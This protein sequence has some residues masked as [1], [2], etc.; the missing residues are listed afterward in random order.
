MPDP[1]AQ[2]TPSCRHRSARPAAS[3]AVPASVVPTWL[4]ATPASRVSSS[5]TSLSLSSSMVPTSWATVGERSRASS[6]LPPGAVPERVDPAT[7][8]AGA[9]QHLAEQL[10]VAERRVGHEGGVVAMPVVLDHQRRQRPGVGRHLPVLPARRPAA[11]HVT[12]LVGHHVAGHPPDAGRQQLI[13][14]G[15]EGVGAVDGQ[16]GVASADQHQVALH[17]AVDHRPAGGHRGGEGLVGAVGRPGRR[18]R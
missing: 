4:T 2:P 5:A 9:G 12:A 1:S 8:I 3:A 7:A 11:A 14:Q 13:D 16:R 15:A 18:P 17:D 6:M 10:A